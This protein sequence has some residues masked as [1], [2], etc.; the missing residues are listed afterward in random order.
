MKPMS[1]ADCP[2]DESCYRI[3]SVDGD[4]SGGHKKVVSIKKGNRHVRTLTIL[5]FSSP[6]KR[7][8]RL[9]QVQ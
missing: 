9:A 7:E 6:S 2:N 3:E 4:E 8:E 5:T 1:A